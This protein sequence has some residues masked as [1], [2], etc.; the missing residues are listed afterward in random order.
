MRKHGDVRF[1]TKIKAEY[2][3]LKKPGFKK[4]VK[5]TVGTMAGT[6]VGALF[7]SGVDLAFKGLVEL[8]L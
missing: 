7:I 5:M 6:V 2:K 4:L 1:W 8:F 3:A